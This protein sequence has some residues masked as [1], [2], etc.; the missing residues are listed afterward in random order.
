MSVYAGPADW[1][2]DSTNDGRTHVTTKGITQDGLVYSLDTGVTT[3]Y[4]G[5]GNTFTDLKG[6]HN[7]TL[8]GPTFS[9]NEGGSLV[10]DGV[11]DFGSVATIP[12]ASPISLANNFTIEQVFKPTAY[13]ISTYFGLTNMLLNKGTAS[14]YNYATQ[15]TNDTTISFIKRTGAEGL[16]FH[17]FAV[18]SMLNKVNVITLVIQNGSNSSIDT[19]SC[20]QNGVFVAS[21]NITGLAISAND[22]EPLYLGGLST[23]LYTNFTGSYYSCR[24]YNRALSNNEIRTN[25]NAIR[26]RY[27]I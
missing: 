13:Q 21:N 22:N 25:F 7:I 17:P 14:T 8:N 12:L 18:S 11:N 20:Y 24:I 1:W 3:S 23:Q 19:V 15:V 5:T 26:G 9:S 6:N 27:G 2:T 4:S 10:F 16:N